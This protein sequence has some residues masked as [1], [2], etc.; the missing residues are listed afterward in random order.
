MTA[1][2]LVP[3]TT[4][5]PIAMTVRSPLA[6]AV[7]TALSPALAKVPVVTAVAAIP[8]THADTWTPVASGALIVAVWLAGMLGLL[9]RFAR[10]SM[11]AG[12]LRARAVVTR[13]TEWAAVIA[14]VE[15]Q[16]GAAEPMDVRL[17]SEVD[18]PLVSG[19]RRPVIVLPT[20]ASEWS[21]DQRRLVLLHEGAHIARRDLLSRAIGVMTCSV[22]WYNPLIWLL[23]AR[24]DV[25]AEQSADDH[26]LRSG[27]RP[28]EYA[29]LLMSFADQ[30]RWRASAPVL[31]LAHRGTLAPRVHAVLAVTAPR[32]VISRRAQVECA[33]L[34][35]IMIVA[36]GCI[37]LAPPV[38]RT[39]SARDD[40]NV[41]P[42]IA[43]EVVVGPSAASPPTVARQS[44][45]ASPASEPGLPVV[46]GWRDDAIRALLELRDDPSPQVRASAIEALGKLRHD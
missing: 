29:S 7:A 16:L 17:S 42:P 33:A 13:G 45:R 25:E 28:S 18:V 2:L 40:R 12:R 26:V 21:V 6:A 9:A 8:A 23:A 38:T 15:T 10:Q 35:A 41:D 37:R 31:M 1:C 19:I 22:H 39:E 11:M 5:L 30:L 32:P 3:G 34:C 4:L 27:V 20:R 46:P 44:R 43:G 24:I 14:A 36:A